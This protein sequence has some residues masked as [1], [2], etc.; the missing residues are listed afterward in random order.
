MRPEGSKADK[1]GLFSKADG[2]SGSFYKGYQTSGDCIW[3][4]TTYYS[5][6]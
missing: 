1:K 4:S 5:E 6:P 3:E 2:I